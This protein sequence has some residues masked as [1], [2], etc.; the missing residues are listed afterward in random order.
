VGAHIA[1]IDLSDVAIDVC[2][3]ALPG[4]DLNVGS[5]ETLPWPD[6]QFDFVTCLR[7]LKH[8][9]DPVS[10]LEEMKRVAKQKAVYFILVGN[11]GFL[12]RRLSRFAGMDRSRVHEVVW[13]LSE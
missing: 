3:M 10:A 8:F 11:S 9:I 2:R 7:S 5:A 6:A 1:G 13:S 12:T 4:S